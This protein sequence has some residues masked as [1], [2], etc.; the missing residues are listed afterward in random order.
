[1]KLKISLF[2]VFSYLLTA[3]ANAQSI[4]INSTDSG[5]VN[6]FTWGVNAPDKWCGWVSSANYISSISN[7]GIKIVRVNPIA[8]CL[9]DGQDP[10]PS[11]GTYNW[12]DLDAQLNTIFNAGAQPL[13]V[14]CGFP[15]AVS[16]TLNGSNQ[17]TSV[18]WTQY[19]TFMSA[20]VNRYNVSKVL[21]ATKT[22]KYWELW[23]EPTVEPDGIMG[24]NPN[25]TG[26]GW[27]TNN[28]PNFVQT[29]G[30]AM[31]TA[32]SSI[33]LLG[34]VDSWANLNT[35]GYLAYTAQNLS[36]YIDILSWHDYGPDTT[37]AA[38]M[39]YPPTAYTSRPTTVAGGNGGEFVG[40]GGK[41]FGTAITE[42]NLCSHSFGTDSEF[43][44]EYGAVYAGSSI[45]N[46]MLGG[47]SI[48]CY[49]ASAE[50]GTNLLGLLNGSDYSIKAK[51]YYVFQLFGT[52]FSKG[53]RKLTTSGASSPI[54]VVASYSST[55][56]KRYIAL[57]NKDLTTSHA[58]TFTISGIGT[59]GG[60]RTVWLVD[61]SNNA[62][63]SS[64]S[65]SGNSFSYTIGARAFAVFEVSPTT[66]TGPLF[67]T[68]F[69][70]ADTQPTWLD[71]IDHSSN[72]TGYTTSVSPECSPRDVAG[73]GGG[74]TAHAGSKAEMFSGTDNSATASYCY[75]KVFSV[76]IP[77]TSS[78]KMSYWILPQQA[79]GRY[80]AVDYH[81]TDGST[82]R[83][84]GATDQNGYSM[85]PNAGHGGSITLNAWTQIKCNVGTW[86]AGKTIDTIYVAY[87][88]P[89]STGQYRGYIDDILITNGTL[90]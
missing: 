5:A 39:A 55:T 27:P 22:I 74:L 57:V 79:N 64:A 2:V 34:P 15:G 24:D 51:A 78:T 35:D 81:C 61:S 87:D 70:T 4:T 54:E 66:G 44:N 3:S 59:S 37:D 90:P 65:Y 11:A 52:Q 10:N 72:V 89:G 17:I 50:S 9:Q 32:Y 33:V 45:V 85:H 28:Y 26:G 53:D 62:A 31:K 48:F 63:S 47:V 6:P 71:T 84:S 86:L 88:Q 25:Y 8:K 16:H 76:S 23:N 83:D 14:V 29:V 77:V 38:R 40:T 7:A 36:S 42:Y 68:G 67:S 56:G 69:E 18:N 30:G 12:T 43:S 75:Y 46:A 20:V 19:A 82:L 1:M 41:L 80:V 21:G 49:Y 13:F 60:T 73:D 58:V